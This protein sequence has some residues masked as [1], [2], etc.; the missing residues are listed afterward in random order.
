[1]RD[2]PMI[3]KEIVEVVRETGRFS[4]TLNVLAP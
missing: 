1:V 3:T 4:L 2:Q